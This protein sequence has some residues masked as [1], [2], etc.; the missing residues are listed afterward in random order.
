M[1]YGLFP[2][3]WRI[4]REYAIHTQIP[5]CEQE[6]LFYKDP[7]DNKL[8]IPFTMYV[9]N[10][11]ATLQR[12]YSFCDLPIPDDVVSNAIRIQSTTHDRTEHRASY[13]PNFNKSLTSLG[14]NETK[15]KEHLSE[16][17][18]WINTLDDFKKTN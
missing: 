7:A 4:A 9:N 11:S 15:I 16:Y 10:L 17:I 2:M 6:M 3:T 12:I 18:A 5:Y 8:V 1:M 14:V 13:D